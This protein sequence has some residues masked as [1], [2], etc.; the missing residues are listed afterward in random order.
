MHA[1]GESTMKRCLESE[2]SSMRKDSRLRAR[3]TRLS[4]KAPDA[5]SSRVLAWKY[6]LKQ[7]SNMRVS[8]TATS[9]RVSP[10]VPA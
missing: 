4:A 3:T 10:T 7:V 9:P 6:S 5:I 8:Q 1:G 2:A